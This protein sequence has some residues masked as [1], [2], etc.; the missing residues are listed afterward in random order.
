MS[1][2]T[3]MEKNE[4]KPPK[5]KFWQNLLIMDSGDLKKVLSLSSLMLSFGILIVYVVTYI[6]LMPLLDR[7]L[8]RG[9]VL[10]VNLAESLIPAVI[11]TLIVMMVWPL[12]RD[13]RVLPAAYSWL[14][15]FSLLIFI[16]VMISLREDSEVRHGFVYIFAWDV[17]PPLL[18]GSITAWVRYRNFL[19]K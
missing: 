9:P 15:F 4:E 16:V 6:L 12:F 7:V 19:W 5:R 1:D 3:G 13:K 11:A 14:L 17:L 8:G 18:I 2:Y 10:L